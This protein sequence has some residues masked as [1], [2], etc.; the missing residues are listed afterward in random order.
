MIYDLDETIQ[1]VE[2]PSSEL[3]SIKVVQGP[4]LGVIYTYGKVHISEDKENDR[5]KVDFDWKL[6]SWPTNLTKKEIEE[7]KEFQDYIGNLLTTLIEEKIK[8]D[9][10][11]NTDT[12]EAND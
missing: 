7:S 6:E 12:E 1:F 9:K 3:Y 11:T 4:Y 8:N 5:A 2:K 10:S